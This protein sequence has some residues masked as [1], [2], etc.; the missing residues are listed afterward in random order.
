[1]TCSLVASRG[2]SCCWIIAMSSSRVR[3]S[4]AL[5]EVE[6]SGWD[7]EGSSHSCLGVRASHYHRF[8]I[9]TMDGELGC[10]DILKGWVECGRLSVLSDAIPVEV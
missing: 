1:M 9:Y 2:T 7:A 10:S 3:L 8:I 5:G 6:R 4:K